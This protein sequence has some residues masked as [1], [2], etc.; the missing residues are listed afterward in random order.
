M[1]A[2]IPDKRDGL[3]GTSIPPADELGK[4]SSPDTFP[5]PPKKPT[6]LQ[7]RD[8]T[9][10]GRDIPEVKTGDWRGAGSPKE[11]ETGV[12]RNTSEHLPTPISPGP[13]VASFFH[14][15]CAVSSL[16]RLAP[17]RS[18]G[19]PQE[20]PQPRRREASTVS[21]PGHPR[22]CFFRSLPATPI[23][24]LRGRGTPAAAL[25]AEPFVRRALDRDVPCRDVPCRDVPCRAGM[26]RAVPG[27]AAPCRDVPC[28]RQPPPP[29]GR[30]L[31]HAASAAPGP[32]H[33]PRQGKGWGDT[34]AALVPVPQE[35]GGEH[36]V[37][38]AGPRGGGPGER[39]AAARGGEK[40]RRAAAPRPAPAAR[41]PPW[42]GT[43]RPRL[44]GGSG[45]F[46]WLHA[47]AARHRRYPWAAPE[48]LGGSGTS[49]RLRHLWK[50]PVP[51]GGSAPRRLRCPGS[52]QR[53]R[54]QRPQ[55]GKRAG[56]A[57]PELSPPPQPGTVTRAPSE[58]NGA[59]R[60]CRRVNP[61]WARGYLQPLCRERA[62]SGICTEQRTKAGAYG[63]VP[64]G[65][66]GYLSANGAGGDSAWGQRSSPPT[67][68][69][70]RAG[71]CSEVGALQGTG[72]AA[73]PTGEGVLLPQPRVSRY[74]GAARFAQGSGGD[75]ECPE[76]SRKG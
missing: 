38:P 67:R 50:A 56:A 59:P 61:G 36:A 10:A 72:V 60:G 70:L 4:H 54:R 22:D 29:P 41:A 3:F 75:T 58:G 51:R 23:R 37:P 31:D 65:G 2:S 30:A 74:R 53:R 17:P 18:T 34:A 42:V 11:L 12:A 21:C 27:C 46:G 43:G 13:A 45:T 52:G 64:A 76:C 35:R 14:R 6:Q 19:G 69:P 62:G 55:P 73:I 8:R 47:R 40:R 16:S 28:R 63:K 57:G 1:G 7:P 44:R 26:C 32:E 48:C 68:P 15:R 5:P 25:K 66:E 24:A 20:P 71:G 39:E 9:K 49:G 33:P